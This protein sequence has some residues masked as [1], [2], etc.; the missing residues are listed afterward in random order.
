MTLEEHQHPLDL[1]SGQR[2]WQALRQD[3]LAGQRPS[4]HQ[5]TF[6]EFSPFHNSI[7]AY[8][9]NRLRVYRGFSF[10]NLT[11][12]GFYTLRPRFA[13]PKI[14]FRMSLGMERSWV[15]VQAHPWR[16]TCLRQKKCS[17]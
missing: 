15:F 17:K 4:C 14:S 8:F 11:R 6:Y 13:S 2:R 12:R 9:N 10:C 3:W 1:G 16:F 7:S 5:H